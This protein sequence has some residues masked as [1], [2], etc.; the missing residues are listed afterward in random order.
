MVRVPSST[1]VQ[2]GM[3]RWIPRYGA[4]AAYK[5]YLPV[6]WPRLGG[7]SH[8]AGEIQVRCV[9]LRES[10]RCGRRDQCFRARTAL[11]CLWRH[12]AVRPSDEAGTRRSDCATHRVAPKESPAF[13][14]GRMSRPLDKARSA[15]PGT[16]LACGVSQIWKE[17]RFRAIIQ[18]FEQINLHP[19]AYLPLPVH[20]PRLAARAHSAKRLIRAS[21]HW[22]DT[23]RKRRVLRPTQS[24]AMRV[25]ARHFTAARDSTVG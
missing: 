23:G 5:P 21:S 8:D 2:A 10:R 13:M 25:C 15:W 1:R 12:G 14:Q 24:N 17:G 16:R 3:D 4:A 11:V 18:R 22:S 6:L 9:R 19:S 20:P 7:E